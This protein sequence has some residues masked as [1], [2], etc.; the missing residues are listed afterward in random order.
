MEKT[1]KWGSSLTKWEIGG[2]V[3][4]IFIVIIAVVLVVVFVVVKPG[5]DSGSTN[6]VV[7]QPSSARP[8]AA[9][10]TRDSYAY[11]LIRQASP[12]VEWP[13]DPLT[14]QDMVAAGGGMY[15][16]PQYRAAHFVLYED[17]N[18]INPGNH[19]FLQRYGL[20]TLW[21]TLGGDRGWT[22]NWNWA[23]SANPCDTFHGVECDLAQQYVT[24]LDLGK[25]GL[26]TTKPNQSGAA[27]EGIPYELST[28]TEATQVEFDDN[29]I[30]GPLPALAIIDMKKL[31]TFTVKRNRLTGTIPAALAESSLTFL[32]L[33]ENQLVGNVPEEFCDNNGITTV[34]VNCQDNDCFCCRGPFC[35]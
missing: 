12:G 16:M 27:A 1:G 13:G 6:N 28:L 24:K 33:D 14:L 29:D 35:E 8:T 7:Q 10:T 5:E 34:V 4:C 18:R 20:Y 21:L 11:R 19:W 9:P 15:V 3:A 30:G 17:P 32:S 25:N 26:S 22:N 31:S 2:I 23:N